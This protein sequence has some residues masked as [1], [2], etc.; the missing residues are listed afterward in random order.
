[1]RSTDE[2][3]RRSPPDRALPFQ[4]L[5]GKGLCSLPSLHPTVGKE[6]H[7]HVNSNLL[8]S[9]PAMPDLNGGGRLPFESPQLLAGKTTTPLQP[10]AVESPYC[11][12]IA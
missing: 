11:I 7:R 2:L 5:Y 8:L 12:V 3:F 1:M 10:S 9:T 4:V 6:Q